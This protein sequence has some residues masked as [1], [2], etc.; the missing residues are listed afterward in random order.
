MRG[1]GRVRIRLPEPLDGWRKFAGEVGIIVLGVLLAL[2]A[3]QAVE[4][5]QERA[6]V[7]E[8]R[9]A[10]RA[11]LG[12]ARARWEDM[13]ARD[14]CALK[15]LDE[16]ERWIADAPPT[17]RLTNGY[18]LILRNLNS[19]AWDIAKMSP[20]AAEIPLEERLTYASLYGSM[21]NWRTILA[22]ERSNVDE[23]GGLLSASNQP[24]LR[25]DALMRIAKARAMVM[26]RQRNYPY[27]FQ[28]FDELG[29]KPDR[30]GLTVALDITA[31]CRPLSV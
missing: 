14:T 24:G 16:I 31:L 7:A 17:S 12:D 11:E 10:L 29:I 13:Q 6:D 27:F 23:L 4:E 20:V 30:S 21:E 8:L 22:D 1:G 5:F 18:D 3:Q 19:H 9:A 2:G 28:R 26:R 25:R 15:R